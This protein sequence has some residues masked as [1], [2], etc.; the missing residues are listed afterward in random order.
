[1]HIASTF[2]WMDTPLSSAHID[3]SVVFSVAAVPRKR[4]NV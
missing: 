2:L 4:R 1:M 3:V